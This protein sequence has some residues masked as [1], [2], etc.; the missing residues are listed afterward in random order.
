[1]TSQEIK[2]QIVLATRE[3]DRRAAI[4]Q[5]GEQELPMFDLAVDNEWI[6]SVTFQMDELKTG[7]PL[8]IRSVLS[9]PAAEG[10]ISAKA[11]VEF[12]GGQED[13]EGEMVTV[14]KAKD[15][16]YAAFKTYIEALQGF[17]A[18]DKADFNAAIDEVLDL[19]L[20]LNTALEAEKITQAAEIDALVQA[21][22][23]LN[24]DLEGEKIY[25]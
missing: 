11:D 13:I 8:V 4:V 10:F 24:A 5:R 16:L 19:R 22:L 1:M 9:I 18:Q 25:D 20:Q 6:K 15:A 21:N 12:D 3:K 17:I 7:K 23:D 14:S 2:E